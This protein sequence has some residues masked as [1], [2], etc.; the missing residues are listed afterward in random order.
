M[1]RWFGTVK[2]GGIGAP[3]WFEVFDSR[4]ALDIILGKPWLC[5]VK[6]IHDYDKDQITITQNG[7]TEVISN[8]LTT[9]PT[10]AIH[11]VQEPAETSP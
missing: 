4:G 6:A 3:S 10:T 2:V 9:Q 5:R 7:N 1:G 11:S 8:L